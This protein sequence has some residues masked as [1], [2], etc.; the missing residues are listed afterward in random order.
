ME[1]NDFSKIIKRVFWIWTALSGGKNKIYGSQRL[2]NKVSTTTV[3]GWKRGDASRILASIFSSIS[4]SV[5]RE[6]T[7]HA[8]GSHH[9]NLNLINCW[10]IYADTTV[11]LLCCWI[12]C[13]P[14]CVMSYQTDCNFALLMLWSFSQVNTCYSKKY[15]ALHALHVNLLLCCVVLNHILILTRQIIL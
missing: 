10:V 4:Y 7:F 6:S 5:L 8:P 9:Q 12:V 13:A 15:K 14:S 11:T 3:S 1:K 2:T